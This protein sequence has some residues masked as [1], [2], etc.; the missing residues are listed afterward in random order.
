M[1]DTK[2]GLPAADAEAAAPIAAPPVA[3]PQ[4]D[5]PGYVADRRRPGRTAHVNP[6]LVPLLRQQNTGA[7]AV[8]LTVADDL[9]EEWADR[10]PARGLMIGIAISL[11]AWAT[12]IVLFV[13]L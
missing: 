12:G 11:V 7:A 8:A 1:V 10:A 4:A 2:T 6:A 3:A 5:P 9:L 13:V